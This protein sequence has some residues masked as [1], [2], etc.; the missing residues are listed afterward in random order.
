ME[1]AQVKEYP[2]ARR[3]TGHEVW[4]KKIE[5]LTFRVE[6]EDGNKVVIKVKD[7]QPGWLQRRPAQARGGGDVVQATSHGACSRDDWMRRIPD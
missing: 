4:K 6:Y 3:E 7:P 2:H 5:A 1:E